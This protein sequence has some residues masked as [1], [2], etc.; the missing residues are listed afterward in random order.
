MIRGGFGI[1][2]DH[3]EGN[4]LGN[5]INSQ[6]YVPW[7]QSASIS[8]T[9]AALSQY[10]TA[11][12]AGYSPAPIHSSLSGVDP[13]LVVAR[14]YQYSLGVQRELPRGHVASGGLRRQLGTAHPAYA[15]LQQCLAGRTQGYIPVSPNPNNAG[16]PCWNK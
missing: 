2:Y 4:V 10:D 1:F 9:N 13:H 8:G 7:A 11:P 3:P 5:G 6:G 14:S 12:G 15:E 16:M